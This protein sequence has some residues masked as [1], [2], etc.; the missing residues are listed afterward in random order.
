M[1]RIKVTSRAR[2]ALAV[3]CLVCLIG[4]TLAAYAAEEYYKGRPDFTV[5]QAKGYFVWKEGG[6]W[7]V[8]WETKGKKITASGTVTCDGAFAKVKKVGAEKGDFIRQQ[9][10]RS[11]GFD[12]KAGGGGDGFDFTLSPST[13]SVTFDLK[14]DGATAPTEMVK[15]GAKKTRPPK[16]PFTITEKAKK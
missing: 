1:R 7:H 14:I 3:G 12:V 9:S 11:I 13:K 6:D 2:W 10:D 8:R 16:V 15:I 5:G 4:G